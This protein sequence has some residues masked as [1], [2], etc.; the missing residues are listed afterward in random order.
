MFQFQT[1]T[2]LMSSFSKNDLASSLN[3]SSMSSMYWSVSA[4]CQTSFPANPESISQ[5]MMSIDVLTVWYKCTHRECRN[6]IYI[7]IYVNH[8]CIT[9]TFRVIFLCC[10]KH[11]TTTDLQS[12]T[13]NVFLCYGTQS[14]GIVTSVSQ[15]T[16]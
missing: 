9:I 7:V 1:L 13:C 15:T 10:K 2:F 11:H 5:C 8:A 12:V 4:V 3:I 14:T 6:Y 16:T